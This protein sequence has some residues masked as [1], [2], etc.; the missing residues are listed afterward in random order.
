MDERDF[1]YL[2][3]SSSMLGGWA[4]EDR[5]ELQGRGTDLYEVPEDGV[6]RV[7]FWLG[8]NYTAVLIARAYLKQHTDDITV[9]WDLAT[10]GPEEDDYDA[11]LGWA[12]VTDYLT[13]SWQEFVKGHVFGS[14]KWVGE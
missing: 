6:P 1:E 4:N 12:I 3:S 5:F 11:S 2:S 8:D 9:L 13:A 10:S 14:G 7:I